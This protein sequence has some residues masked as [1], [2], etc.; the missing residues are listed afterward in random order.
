MAESSRPLSLESTSLASRISARLS[1]YR[2]FVGLAGLF[3]LFAWVA[4]NWVQ[5]VQRILR[6]Y[7]P[8][9]AW[10]YWRTAAYLRSYEAFD[11][12]VLWQQHNEHRIVFPEIVFAADYLLFHGRQI[13]P[14][15]VSFLCYAGTWA[16]L[17][18]SFWSIT[19]LR[20]SLRALGILLAGVIIGWQGSAIVLAAAFLLQWTLLELA[21]LLSLA[22][23]IRLKE[24]AANRYLIATICCAEIATYSSGNGLLLWPLLI[25]LALLISAGKR[26]IIM[27]AVTACISIAVYFIGYTFTDTLSIRKLLLHPFYSLKFTGAYLSMPF[28]ALKSASFGVWLGIGSLSLMVVLAILAFRRGLLVSRAGVVLFG[29]YAFVVLTALLTAAGR[30][31]PSELTFSAAKAPRYVSEPLIAWGVFILLCLWLCARSHRNFRMR[32]GVACV[33]SALLLIAFPKFRW[34]LRGANADY[35]N[36]QLAA[37]GIELGLKDPGVILN[38][39]PDPASINIWVDGLREPHLSVFYEGQSKWLGHEMHSFAPL[40]NSRVPGEITYTFPVLDGVEVGGWFDDSQLRG[41]TAWILL[42]NGEG[43]IVGFGRR[44]PAGFPYVLDNPRTPPTLGWAG[45]VNLKYP[46]KYFSAYLINKHG[47]LRLQGSVPIPN[48]RP[49]IRKPDTPPLKGLGWQMDASWTAN[50]LRPNQPFGEGPSDFY[51]SWSGSDANTGRITS[52]NF[53]APRN[54]CL[55]LPVLQGPGAGGLSAGIVDADS[56]RVLASVPFQNA[57]KQWT[58]WRLPFDAPA[59]RLRIVAE[60]QGKDWGE[61]LAVGNPVLCRD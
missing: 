57:V 56:G 41:G 26:Q 28:G 4:F 45:F 38:I 37:L 31:D 43:K 25:G 32:I 59:E 29:A 58:F 52:S 60:D 19:S 14:L 34:W 18:W 8:L 22:F 20:R 16:V 55:I 36:Q 42:V 47:L 39:F 49:T 24:T 1:N 27:L 48:V 21:V 9:P 54:A 11:L 51:G 5:T 44:L 2:G 10:D 50:N 46:T 53:T 7:N 3:L 17:A 33:I 35:A 13:L 61:W 40:V 6:Y 15:A 23:L 12:R 30:L